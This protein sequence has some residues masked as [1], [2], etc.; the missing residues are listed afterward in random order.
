MT[1][2]VTIEMLHA[3]NEELRT[4]IVAR[5]TAKPPASLASPAKLPAPPSLTPGTP[6]TTYEIA[7]LKGALEMLSP[8]ALRGQGKLYEPG[9]NTVSENYWLVVIWAVASLGWV[10]G[11]EVARDWSM[12]SQ[13]YT[14]EGFEAAWQAYDPTRPN[15][16]GIGSLYKLAIEHGWKPLR[17]NQEYAASVAANAARY[18]VLSPTDIQALPAL[19]WRVKTVLPATGLAAMFGPS[20]SGKS[21]LALDL[22][23]A[24]ANGTP[25]F[26]F[27]VSRAPVVYVMLEGEGGIRNRV[28]ALEKAQGQ[29]PIGWFGVIAQQFHLTAPQDV[30]DLAAVITDGAVVFIDT[31]NRAAPTSDEN[32][33]KEM[34]NILQAAKDLQASIGG[35]VVVVHHTGK[36][37]TKGMRGHSSLHA[38]LDAAIEVER[39]ASGSRHWSLAKAKEGEDGKQV[40]F[41][42][43][44]HV[45]GH[46]IDGDEVASC[47]VEPDLAPLFVKAE[48]KGAK[49]RQALKTIRTA[50][51]GAHASTGVACCPTGSKAIKVEAVVAEVANTLTATPPNKRNHEA[52]RLAQA[53]MASG[54]LMS[55]LDQ[56]QEAWCW[57]E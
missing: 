56:A 12:Q 15:P 35:L 51:S 29:L 53:L 5:Q 44:R 10:C 36:D 8:D 26:G 1:T 37:P 14:D 9:D 22:A 30:A 11:K 24:I 4:V 52:R 25:W 42:L 16:I 6:E 7:K 13:R 39:T 27:R 47:S 28:A 54:H 33:S 18:Q 49:Q 40:A 21:F 32:S 45:L 50:L 43:K 2:N 34:G 55:A 31:L 48:P 46:D 19:Q 23:A 17:P 20:G 3:L 38:A 41:R 57:I